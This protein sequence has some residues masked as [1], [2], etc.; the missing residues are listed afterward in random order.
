MDVSLDVVL[1]LLEVLLELLEAVLE[2]LEVDL[3]LREVFQ[4]LCSSVNLADFE[5]L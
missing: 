2:L 5:S 1:E 3:G 4:C